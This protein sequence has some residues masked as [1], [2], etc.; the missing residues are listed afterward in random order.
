MRT[1]IIAEAGVN[2]N[3]SLDLAFKLVDSAAEAGADIVKFQTGV[4]ERV[5]SRYA[6]KA[7]YQKQTTDICE[8][9]LEMAKRLE[10]T[11]E[12]HFFLKARCE[13]QGI[14]FMSS[15]FDEISVDFLARS[16][17][18]SCLKIPSGEITNAPLLLRSAQTQCEI[19]LS[20]GMSTLGEI[21]D[22][23]GV[24]AFGYLRKE[25]PSREAFR[26]SFFSEEGQRII[27]KKVTLLHCTT[28]YPAPFEEI[29]LNVIKTLQHAFDLPVGYSDHTKGIAI[30][31][32]A[33]VLGAHVIEKHFTL[34]RTLSGPDHKASLEPNELK[35][36]IKSIREVEKA[37]GDGKK[38]PTKSELNNKQIARKSLT[39]NEVI[40]TGSVFS[41]INITAKR[42][43]DGVSPMLYWDYIG[44]KA[45]KDYL[46]DEMI[47]N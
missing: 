46:E 22:A 19:Y 18:V 31:I 28:E 36:M 1:L 11:Q 47:D 27:K 33:V 9:Q 13:E 42:P 32:A 41:D 14:Q 6:P 24:L 40:K 15:P 29:N 39:A 2:H 20:T 3:G 38:M 21:E 17:G 7:D 35:L 30:P 4:A 8:S 5:I 25:K 23:L 45:G 26:S 16:L 10:L 44:K 43:G 34:D 12:E 37:I